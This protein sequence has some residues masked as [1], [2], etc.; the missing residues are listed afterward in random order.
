MLARLHIKSVLVLLT[1][2]GMSTLAFAHTG[3]DAGAHD[4]PLLV[5]LLHPLGGMDH[6]AVA[7]AVG[8]WGALRTSRIWLAPVLFTSGMLLGSLLGLMGIH[9]ASV[10][11]VIAGSL[12]ALG[13]M[14]LPVQKQLPASLCFALLAF[15][16]SAHGLA[17]GQELQSTAAPVATLVGLMLTTGLLHLGGVF[18]QRQLVWHR[19]WML[20]T[21]S[22]ALGGLGLGF[23]FNLAGVLG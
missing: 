21:C 2:I 18:V 10:E 1:M 22:L 23:F 4:H 20:R 12:I 5:G 16:G 3:V 6:I 7:L 8:L 17:H 13:V 9:T 11:W 15:L 19:V 14:L